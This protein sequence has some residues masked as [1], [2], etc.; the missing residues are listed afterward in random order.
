MMHALWQI[1]R[2]EI[3]VLL[4]FGSAGTFAIISSFF[5]LY[6]SHRMENRGLEAFELVRNW[7]ITLG[8]MLLI[9]FI[10]KLTNQYSRLLVTTWAACAPGILV[11]SRLLIRGMAVRMRENGY[12]SRK[13]AIIG[14]GARAESIRQTI[15]SKPSLGLRL[16]GVYTPVKESSPES[17]AGLDK[18]TE[19]ARKGEIDIAYICLENSDT[20][21]TK[22]IIDA[23]SDTTT[24]LFVVPDAFTSELMHNRWSEL[25]GIPVLSVRST[26]FYGVNSI[27]KRVE[28][29][30]LS[31]IALML[32]GLPMI[33]IAVAVK[34]SSK[35]PAIYKQ[36]RYGMGGQEIEVWKFRTM[37]VCES[38][39]EFSQT[40]KNDPR[41]TNIGKFLRK[42]SLDELPQF[43]NVLQ[44]R[45]SVIGP[46]PHASKQNEDYR[47]KIKGYMIRHQVKP[48]ISGWAQVNGWRGETDSLDKMQKRVEYD[49]DYIEN[50]S[51]MLDLKIFFM[52]LARGFSDKNAY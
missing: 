3:Y 32:A 45:M 7:V 10:L 25:A 14:T 33:A 38:D 39:D 50:W 5:H 8:L 22:S 44:G 28:D 4:A 2:L 46:R 35:G 24:S 41:I 9:G 6:R 49:L 37:S 47:K 40:V 36:K 52:S 13:A 34:P 43:I 11:L 20:E 27:V 21:V 51:L 23:F 18:L 12:N 31:S 29:I 1:S 16:T 15:L 26:P 19:L 17:A 42:T 48:G 30:V